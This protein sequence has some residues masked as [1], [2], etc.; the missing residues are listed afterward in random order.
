MGKGRVMLLSTT[1]DRE[2][3]DLPI[4]AGFLPLVQEAARRLAGASERERHLG[5]HGGPAPRASRCAPDERRLEITKPDG[6]VWV[7]SKDRG[8]GTRTV[9][10]TETDEPGR[11]P[12]AQRRRRRRCC[13]T[14][15]ADGFVVNIDPRESE[16]RAP[17][18]RPAP[19]PQGRRHRP[20]RPTAQAPGRAVARTGGAADPPGPV[21]V[22]AHPALAPPGDRCGTLTEK[23]RE[24][25]R[26]PV[27]A[28]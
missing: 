22:P 18:A 11:L 13:P 19:R 26:T 15:P 7:A 20:A 1:V 14:A 27:R 2:W 8:G 9:L 6:T 23:K 28:V 25:S 10:F 21:R 16:P 17:G 3:T 5:A 4:R 24:H 12:G